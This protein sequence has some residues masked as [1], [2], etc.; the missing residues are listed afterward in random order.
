MSGLRWIL[1]WLVVV[2]S[3]EVATDAG[4]QTGALLL[5]GGTN[6]K[7]FLGCINC[8]KYDAASVCNKHGTFGSKYN[9]DS[10]WNGYGTFGSKYSIDSPWNQYTSSGPI[11]VDQSGG[12][13]GYFFR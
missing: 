7:T 3:I 11:I 6:H 2:V 8:N 1:Y 9:S 5:F 10:I 12:L 13:Y 4:A